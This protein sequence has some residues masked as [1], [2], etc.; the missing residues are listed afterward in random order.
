MK[1]NTCS[2]GMFI[3]SEGGWG[4]EEKGLKH[5]KNLGPRLHFSRNCPPPQY[6]WGLHLLYN[7]T[8]SLS[9]YGT[10]F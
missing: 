2:K 5:H 3:Y 6:I 9:L 1:S 8:N 10:A 4:A 7:I